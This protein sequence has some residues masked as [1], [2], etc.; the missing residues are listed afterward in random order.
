MSMPE[1]IDFSK[2]A[3]KREEEAAV[4]S[5]FEIWY[6]VLSKFAVQPMPVE[7]RVAMIVQTIGDNLPMV[8]AVLKKCLKDP[9][10]DNEMV[11]EVLD[12]INKL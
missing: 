6:Q 1:F 10:F 2:E 7:A 5:D 3:E 12:E 9:E 8:K 4:L 11:Q